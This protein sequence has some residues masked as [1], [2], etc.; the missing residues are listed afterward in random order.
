MI[1]EKK[2]IPGAN[3][4]LVIFYDRKLQMPNIKTYVYIGKN[5]YD[6]RNR[7]GGDEWFFQAPQLYLKQ[8]DGQQVYKTIEKKF[9]I[10]NEDIL[11]HM[12][13]LQGLIEVLEKVK[14]GTLDKLGI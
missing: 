1:T 14:D 4:F 5:L 6:D 11:H 10:A 7:S 8:G 9:F 2:L 3:Y 12:Y 13:D